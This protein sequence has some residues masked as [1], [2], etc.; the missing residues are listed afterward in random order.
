MSEYCYGFDYLVKDKL[1]AKVKV[2]S[3]KVTVDNFTDDIIDAPF[4]GRTEVSLSDLQDFYEYRCFPE[5]RG[6]AKQLLKGKLYG[7]NR[8]AIIYDTHGI[9]SDDYYWIRFEN[10]DL[11]WDDVKHWKFH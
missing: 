5:S 11:K 4:G 8:L 3:D 9:M 2:Y 7:Y 6:N 1:L 10:Q